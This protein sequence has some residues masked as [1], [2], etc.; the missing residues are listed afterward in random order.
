[1][2][3]TFSN[4]LINN[5]IYHLLNFEKHGSFQAAAR[6][7]AINNNFQLVLLSEDFNPVFTVETRHKKTVDE[8]VRKGIEKGIE[9]RFTSIDVEGILTY[10][11]P[12]KIDGRKYYLMLVDNENSYSQD[13]I[14]DW[15]KF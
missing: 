8:V 15:L 2:G 12:V 10:W 14:K 9:G 7:A 6:E 13:D 4:D 11:G 3:E 5:T 1:M